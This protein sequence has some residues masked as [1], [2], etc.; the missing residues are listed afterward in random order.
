MNSLLIVNFKR[1]GDVYT[2]SHLIQ[3]VKAEN[4]HCK[5]GMVVFSEFE[6]AARNINDVDEIYTVSRKRLSTLLKNKIF[7]NAKALEEVHE[8]AHSILKGSWS[9]L[10][11][12]SND[13]F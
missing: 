8:L 4:P 3:S 2:T 5:I 13:F 1:L 12:M 7:N 9:E 10:F 6:Q 11:N